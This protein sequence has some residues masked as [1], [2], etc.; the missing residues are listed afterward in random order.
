MKQLNWQNKGIHKNN[1]FDYKQLDKGVFEIKHS[2]P[3]SDLESFTIEEID[4]YIENKM[5][6]EFGHTLEDQRT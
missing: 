1:I 5:P 6:F 3:Y 2:I 4:E